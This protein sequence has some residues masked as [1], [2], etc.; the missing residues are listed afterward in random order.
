MRLPDAIPDSALLFVWNAVGGWQYAIVDSLRKF[1]A[2]ESYPCS[3]CKITHGM[4]GPKQEWELF[5]QSW[6][7]TVYFLH[8]NEFLEYLP[9]LKSKYREFPV[10]LEFKNQ[11][12][13]TVV[14][15]ET[16]ATLKNVAELKRLLRNLDKANQNSKT[17]N[18]G[19]TIL[20]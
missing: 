2:P 17:K 5:L 15:S 4:L 16:L 8:R 20:L 14:T 13:H 19:T 9:D 1:L 12:W 10:I 3:L 6:K 11:A 7:R 18:V